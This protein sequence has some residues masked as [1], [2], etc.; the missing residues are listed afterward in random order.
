MQFSDTAT[1]TTAR[2]E[3]CSH[4]TPVRTSDLNLQRKPGMLDTQRLEIDSYW[5]QGRLAMLIS[6]GFHVACGISG[7][8][9]GSP[10]LVWLQV[11]SIAVFG[12]CYV[13][14]FRNKRQ[15]VTALIWFD[16]LG[17]STLAAWIVGPQSGFQF[18]SWILLPLVFTNPYRDLRTKFRIAMLLSVTYV[19]VDWGLH[20][21]TPLA[22]LSS[23][24]VAAFRYF[25]L[26]SFLLATTLTAVSHSRSVIF[27]ENRLR[28]A[29]GTDEL[30]GLLNRRRMSDQ[31]QQ[32]M[33]RAAER[34]RPLAV[35]L[36]DIDH[37]KAIND[38]HGH[39]R[40]DR[41]IAR[42]G[43][44]LQQ[45]VRQQDLAARW[46]GEEFMVVLPDTAIDVAMETAERIRRAIY[47]NVV[48]SSSNL[49]PVSVTIGVAGWRTGESL[50]ATI[51]R[52]D[53]AL[54]AGKHEGRNR[55][56]QAQQ[57]SVADWG[58]PA[59]ENQAAAGR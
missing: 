26:S 21:V 2:S 10:A 54:Y 1:R 6:I 30:S 55:V 13:L 18:Y 28:S 20:Q 23:Q 29:A 45:S 11:L 22:Q 40:G 47:G 48:R 46:G 36:L 19:I 52:A 53:Q 41:V 24:A 58:H 7:A 15:I 4:T 49:L 50:E 37:F 42:V 31:L 8:L 59:R 33:A 9:M 56:V 14:S 5:R 32:E 35:L 34:R 38:D 57:P 51:H 43:E 25:N 3:E 17:Q 12:A 27:A 39:M 44:M 16:L